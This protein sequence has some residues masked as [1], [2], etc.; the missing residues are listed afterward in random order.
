MNVYSSEV[1]KKIKKEYSVFNRGIN[2]LY[3][4][5]VYSLDSYLLVF[6]IKEADFFIWHAL[7]R[8]FFQT[9]IYYGLHRKGKL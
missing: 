9:Y 7:K 3:L 8:M 5:D 1:D 6:N 4:A 2:R